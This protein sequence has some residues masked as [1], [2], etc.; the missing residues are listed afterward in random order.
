M[1]WL[2]YPLQI[3]ST[4]LLVISNSVLLCLDLSKDFD[5]VN[6]PILL[7]KL[8]HYTVNGSANRLFHFCQ[9]KINLFHIMDSSHCLLLSH[10]VPQGSLLGPL[11]SYLY[12][13]LFKHRMKNI[14]L[15]ET[16]LIYSLVTSMQNLPLSVNV[17][18][19]TN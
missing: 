10:G 4:R 12:H 16:L 17:F 6:Y 19:Q 3:I 5:I 1:K 9:I 15:R 13:I 18:I 11:F 2:L 7:S 14:M 8:S